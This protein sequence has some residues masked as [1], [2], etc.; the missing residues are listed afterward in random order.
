[1]S[2]QQQRLLKSRDV[3]RW[4]VRCRE[5]IEYGQRFAGFVL[6]YLDQ[7]LHAA[8]AFQHV[9]DMRLGIL[10]PRLEV[11]DRV[12]TDKILST[13]RPSR[14][15]YMDSGREDLQLAASE[16]MARPIVPA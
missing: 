3:A 13:A 5:P 12:G 10:P 8:H 7:R 9:A 6:L 1:M 4:L 11:H 16:Q 14:L 15:A 2:R